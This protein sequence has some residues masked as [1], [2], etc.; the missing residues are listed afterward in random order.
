M[1][2]AEAGPWAFAHFH[3]LFIALQL[4]DHRRQFYSVVRHKCQHDSHIAF[5]PFF[6]GR[7]FGSHL[8]LVHDSLHTGDRLDRAQGGVPLVLELNGPR[9]RDTAFTAR[10]GNAAWRPNSGAGQFLRDLARNSRIIDFSLR[11]HGYQS[12]LKFLDLVPR[13]CCYRTKVSPGSAELS[14]ASLKLKRSLASAATWPTIMG[15]LPC[16]R[17]KRLSP[18]VYVPLNCCGLPLWSTVHVNLP[19]PAKA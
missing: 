18:T 19:S 5:R 14:P 8:H 15:L 2:Q 6:R 17:T 3:G 12:F 9:E 11:H 4:Q 13:T 1:G 7:L 16:L 10:Y